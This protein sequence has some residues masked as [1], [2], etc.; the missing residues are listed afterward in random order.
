MKNI[1]PWDPAVELAFL[2]FILKQKILLLCDYCTFEV[3]TVYSNL[4]I[5]HI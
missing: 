1:P 5:F 2:P 4:E 3:H